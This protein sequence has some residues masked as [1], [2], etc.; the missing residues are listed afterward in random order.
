MFLCFYSDSLRLC[1]FF[2]IIILS[3]SLINQIKMIKKTIF[4][5]KRNKKHIKKDDSTKNHF[6]FELLNFSPS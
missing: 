3:M 5:R 1:F 4:N 6:Y 2:I